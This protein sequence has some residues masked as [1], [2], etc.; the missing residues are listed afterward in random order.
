MYKCLFCGLINS[1]ETAKFCTECG[2]SSPD[3]GWTPQDVDQQSKVANYAAILS[4]FYFDA[5]NELEIDK[6]SRKLREKL[7]ISHKT[8]LEI[9]SKFTAQKKAFVHI[10]K[11]RLEFNENV[12]DAFAGHG[13]GRY[14]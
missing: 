13:C 4:E 2:P 11:F 6:Y 1:S 8:H 12:I 3:K 5:H 9:L 7:R 10:S 14:F